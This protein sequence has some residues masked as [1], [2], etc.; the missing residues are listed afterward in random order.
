MNRCSMFKI[1]I[2][3]NNRMFMAVYPSVRDSQLLIFSLIKQDD[4][5]LKDIRQ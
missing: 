3:G 1:R 2:P 4:T 5:N